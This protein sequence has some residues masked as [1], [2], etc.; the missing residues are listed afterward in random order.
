MLEQN[1]PSN[2]GSHPPVSR[3]SAV[4]LDHLVAVTLGMSRHRPCSGSE[5]SI[6]DLSSRQRALQ[7]S[8]ALMLGT[9]VVGA[10]SVFAIRSVLRQDLA[11]SAEA[12]VVIR[13]AKLRGVAERLG[14]H[15]RGF[16][17][18]ADPESFQRVTRDRE[19]FFTRLDHLLDSSAGSTRQ[20][21]VEVR[22]A[23]EDYDRALEGVLVER[24]RGGS[25][26]TISRAFDQLVRPRKATLDDALGRLIEEEEA[27]LDS[28][29]RSTER[30]TSRLALATSGVALG[31]LIISVLLALK[32]A[33][34]FRALRTKQRDLEQAMARLEHANGDLEAFAGR[35]AHDLRTPLTPIAL[36]ASRLK[37]SPDETTVRLAQKI[38]RSAGR[39]SRMV[40]D[41][42]AFSRMG[43]RPDESV[44]APAAAI[45][46]STLDDFS[47]QVTADSVTLELNLDEEVRIQ[48]SEAL[49][50]QVVGNLI[51]NALKFVRGRE[52]RLLRIALRGTGAR[53]ELE[54]ADS[55][56]GIPAEAISQIF[57]P[58][59]RAP[60]VEA[61]GSGI[62]LATVRRIVDAYGGS[63]TVESTAGEGATFRVTMPAATTEPAPLLL[64]SR[65]PAHSAV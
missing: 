1:L 9:A 35:I 29:D 53:C 30:S 15:A 18:T 49:F 37:R 24:R 65:T 42:L 43:R 34:A 58:F 7:I 20:R 12:Q 33:G 27:R 47:E 38:E 61:P 36:A 44:T 22:T 17:L 59:Y 39:A 19:V 8:L 26:Q 5:R 55:G 4:G 64:H 54:V 50:R 14:S 11:E 16:L 57:D 32:L 60:N 13:L 28:M 41:L 6:M 3:A 63:V 25:E 31:A 51:G 10:A 2:S 23:A 45:I 46:R 52:R 40:E 48:C 62:G 56:P 21:L